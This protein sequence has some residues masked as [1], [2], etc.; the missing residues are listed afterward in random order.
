MTLSR[1][2]SHLLLL[3]TLLGSSCASKRYLAD[4][5]LIMQ[6]DQGGMA[7]P[8]LSEADVSPA[9][10]QPAAR[11]ILSSASLTLLVDQPDSIHAINQALLALA[12][13][14]GGYASELGTVR[15]EIRVEREHLPQ[16]LEAVKQLGQ[17]RGQRLYSQDVTEQYLDYEIR[18]DNARK[19]RDRYLALLA[20]AED[21][22]AAL[23]VEHELERLNATI[24]Q[25]QGRLN[26]LEHLT[27]FA[28]ISIE[29][30][31]RK[32]P[33]P[34]GYLGIGLYRAVKW[35]FVRN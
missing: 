20:K 35:L 25:L 18:L 14:H 24:D 33:G 17:V 16:V 9:P 13:Q 2:S 23:R 21:V 28:T 19:A 31:T 12:Q 7:S 10:S 32:K 27:T 5:D 29:L 3:L 26:R 34:I 30:R 1:L 22:Q 4:D 8:T 6:R 15:S 11:M